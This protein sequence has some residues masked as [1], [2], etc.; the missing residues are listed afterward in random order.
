MSFSPISPPPHVLKPIPVKTYDVALAK[1]SYREGVSDPVTRSPTS[2]DHNNTETNTTV[3][4]FTGQFLIGGSYVFIENGT[5]VWTRYDSD[6]GNYN[7]TN[8]S[9]N[10]NISHSSDITN[11]A[12]T[13]T[14]YMPLPN[15]IIPYYVGKFTIPHNPN[16][17]LTVVIL[18]GE[19]SSC[20]QLLNTSTF[21]CKIWQHEYLEVINQQMPL[22]QVRTFLP[23]HIGHPIVDLKTITTMAAALASASASSHTT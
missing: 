13:T 9:S 1:T 18:N 10:S 3:A 5:V 4:N 14:T 12:T 17:Q 16:Y 11:T 19:I 22:L 23:K 21:Y 6:I 2:T 20:V 8:N 15:I 7:T